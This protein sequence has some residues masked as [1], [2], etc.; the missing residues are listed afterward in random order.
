MPIVRDPG[1]DARLEELDQVDWD[2]SLLEHTRCPFLRAAAAAGQLKIRNG[3]N[4]NEPQPKPVLIA[5]VDSVSQ[6][7][8][9]LSTVLAFF[10]KFNHTRGLFAGQQTQFGGLQQSEFNL[11]QTTDDNQSDGTH[12]GGVEIIRS[13]TGEFNRAVIARIEAK[14]QG[15]DVLT[16][17]TMAEVIIDANGGAFSD[18]NGGVRGGLTDLAKSAGEWALMFCLLQ[19]EDGNVPIVDL[20]ALCREAKV[21][22]RGRENLSRSSA[23]EWVQYTSV[24]TACIVHEKAGS[25]DIVGHMHEMWCG[26]GWHSTPGPG[27]GCDKCEGPEFWQNVGK[28]VQTAIDKLRGKVGGFAF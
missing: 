28:S 14:A 25:L 18:I 5:T 3:K 6:A 19:D 20:M 7:G 27:C 2:K 22:P 9:G 17:K 1:L 12:E 10:A 15:S 26:K 11:D 16:P 4:L 21:P 23:H 13:P 24:I 8:G